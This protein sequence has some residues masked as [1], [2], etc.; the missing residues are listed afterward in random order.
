MGDLLGSP[1]VAPLFFFFFFFFLRRAYP[2]SLN[3][4][5]LNSLAKASLNDL[6]L[7]KLARAPQGFAARLTLRRKTCI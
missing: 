7:G 6:I 4:T 1:R 3:G 5:I 2:R